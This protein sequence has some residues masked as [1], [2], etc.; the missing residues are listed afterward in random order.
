MLSRK[1]NELITR[2]DKGTPLGE[3]FRRYW[4]PALLS[5]ELPEPDCDPVRVRLLGEDLVAFRDS[6]GRPGLLGE[7]CA[8]RRASLYFGRNEE[9]GL[10]CAYHGWKYDVNGCILDTP[11]EPSRST[12]KD[13]VRLKAYP[14]IER[15][16]AIFAYMGPAEKQPPFP[17]YEWLTVAPDHVGATKFFLDCNYLQALEGDCDT[18]HPAYLHRGNNGEG[19]VPHKGPRFEGDTSFASADNLT[20]KMYTTWCGLKSADIRRMP[21]GRANYRISTFAM[22][23]IGSVPISRGVLPGGILDGFQV[24]YQVPRD[25]YSTWRYNFRFTRTRPIT[26]EDVERDRNQVRPDHYL[27]ANRSNNYLLDRRKQRTINFSGI[28]GFATQDAAMTESMGAI[29]DRSEEHLGAKDHYVVALRRYLIK[30][31]KDYQKGI[32]PPGTAPGPDDDWQQ[33]TICTNVTVERG[34]DWQDVEARLY[35]L[36]RPGKKLVAVGV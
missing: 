29:L 6:D 10:R 32:D 25:D 28:D 8:H 31:A 20:T 35:D 16:G 18:S 36:E 34:E 3:V 19:L 24:V 33:A 14:C 7:L 26:P 5:S 23:C 12:I 27:T 1:D 2:S 17:E 21:G 11:A 22:P 4:L 13:R 15:S 9:G 30:V